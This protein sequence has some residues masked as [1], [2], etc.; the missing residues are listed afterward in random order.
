LRSLQ[1][2]AQS[3]PSINEFAATQEAAVAHLREI[4]MGKYFS[5]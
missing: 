3:N 5:P 2:E 4:N 1:R